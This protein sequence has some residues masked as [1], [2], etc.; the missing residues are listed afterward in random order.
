MTPTSKIVG[1]KIAQQQPVSLS[2]NETGSSSRIPYEGTDPVQFAALVNLADQ[3]GVQYEATQAFGK[4]TVTF[5]YPYN[6]GIDPAT[7]PPVNLWEK[8]ST[9]VQKSILDSSNPLANSLVQADLNLLDQFLADTQQFLIQWDLTTLPIPDNVGTI[10]ATKIQFHSNSAQT[11]ANLILSGVTSFDVFAPTLRYT[12]CVNSSYPIVASQ[13]NVGSIISTNSL[14]F[15]TQIPGNLLFSLP[16]YPDPVPA[17]ASKPV[18]HYGWYKN[19]PEVRQIAKL[20]WQIVYLYEYGLWP[21]ALYGS[22]I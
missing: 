6:F 4:W 15:L 22:P 13:V 18:L 1:T 12:Q 21:E 8:I 9:K 3:S 14:Y 7:E 11:L 16:N 20:K 5:I 19:D 10:D 17:D 2:R